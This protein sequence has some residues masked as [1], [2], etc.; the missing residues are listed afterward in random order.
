MKVKVN[1]ATPTHDP[2]VLVHDSFDVLFMKSEVSKSA[3]FYAREGILVPG[4]P[5]YIPGCMSLTLVESGPLADLLGAAEG[6]A[7]A[8]WSKDTQKFKRSYGTAV[9]AAKL[10]PI[11]RGVADKIVQLISSQSGSFD[12]RILSQFF[13]LPDKIVIIDPPRP[14]TPRAP[15]P[16]NVSPMP[17]GFKVSA[18]EMPKRNGLFTI[19]VAYEVNRGNAFKKY[20]TLDFTFDNATFD[21]VNCVIRRKSA[22]EILLEV[23]EAA[24]SISNT[25]LG[26]LRDIEVD[27]SFQQTTKAVNNA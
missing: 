6:P 7:H 2:D 19:K 23:S 3:T 17:G 12:N 14:P 24:F 18:P 1:V 11:V 16:A 20:N 15:L 8:D 4:R 26:N 5:I 21:L 13:K 22:N 27:M 25:E 9:K 10:I